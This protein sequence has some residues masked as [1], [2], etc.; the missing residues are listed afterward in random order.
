MV[1]KEIPAWEAIFSV[2]GFMKASEVQEIREA[3]H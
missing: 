3:K 1:K 2:I